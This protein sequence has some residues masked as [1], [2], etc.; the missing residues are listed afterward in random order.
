MK[1]CALALKEAPGLNSRILLGRFVPR[2]SLDV[3]CLVALDDGSDLA[4]AK[5]SN[6]DTKSL[7]D[8]AADMR[9]KA[10]KLRQHKDRDFEASKPLL[11]LLP[12]WVLEPVVATVGYLAGAMGLNIPALGVRPFPFGSAMV[13]SVG[14]L[15]VEQALVPFTPFARVP[16]LLMVGEVAPRAVVAPDGKTVIVQRT[17][18]ITGTIDHR[19]ADG[20]EAARL[21]KR[22]KQA[23]ENPQLLED[24]TPMLTP[25]Q[26]K[27]EKEKSRKK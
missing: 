27:A 20:S 17:L 25:E 18:T 11:A 22:L 15:G 14:M 4:V 19:F 26:R 23:L 3:A 12:V 9:A 16:L 5:L 24:C 8:L 1:A 21:S 2:P 13:T 6:V 10:D 7:G